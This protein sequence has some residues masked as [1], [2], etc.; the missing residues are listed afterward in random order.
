MKHPQALCRHRRP[1]GAGDDYN[2]SLYG[3][4]L[5][6]TNFCIVLNAVCS[7]VLYLSYKDDIFIF[8]T[9]MVGLQLSH[10]LANK[11]DMY[12]MTKIF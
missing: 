7:I 9:N 3:L 11:I 1:D 8:L 2:P 4:G 12:Y 5:K 10:N 6:T